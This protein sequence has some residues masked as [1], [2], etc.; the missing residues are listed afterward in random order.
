MRNK[1][2]MLAVTG[3]LSLCP[4]TSLLAGS[5]T[6]PGET[7]GLAAG[8]PL[9][10]GF[11]FVN[12]ADWGCRDTNPQVC[13]GVTIP[14]GAWSTPWTFL[15]ARIQLLVATPAVE[16]GVNDTTHFASFYNP[17]V[18][19]Q[20]AWDLGGGFGFS[21]LLGAYFD[22]NGDAAW[23]STS[24]N[25]RFALS[26]TAN[27]WN[28]TAN[29]IWGIHLDSVTDRPQLSPCP[30]PFNL[31]GCNPDFVN[32]DLT[33]GRKFGQ[34][35]LAAVGFGSW[36]VSTPIESYAKQSQFALGG[37][38]GYDFGKVI[39]QTYAT[40]DITETNYGGKD[41]RVWGRVIVLLGDPF[42]QPA[43]AARPIVR[44]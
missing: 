14:V 4:S 39:L 6:Q 24:I 3:V 43:P 34:W 27:N 37:L 42:A 17:L 35:Q 22:V 30:A 18:A 16:V 44:K 8:A 26:Y 9:P 31:S 38:V 13:V 12:T 1:L 28:L 23:S 2:T 21:Y 19:G 5:V 32:L 40:T 25:Q 7:V 15:G 41:T 33:A 11:Y 29:L 36:D 20:L 10:P